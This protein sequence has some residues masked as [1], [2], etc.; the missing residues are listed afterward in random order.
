MFIDEEE[1]IILRSKH[2]IRKSISKTMKEI[3]LTQI[4]NEKNLPLL[5]GKLEG[6]REALEIIKKEYASSTKSNNSSPQEMLR[7]IN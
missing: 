1:E 4:H 5:E 3:N 7:I 6:L 2:Y